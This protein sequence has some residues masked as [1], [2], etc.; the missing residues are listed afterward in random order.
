MKNTMK[1]L[2]FI[3]L[4]AVMGFTFAACGDN[5][6][7]GGG[8]GGGG[9]FTL[10]DIPAEYNG[11]DAQLSGYTVDYTISLYGAQKIQINP[12]A[13]TPCKISNGSVS[14]PMWKLSTNAEGTPTNAVRYTGNDLV[15]LSV[16]IYPEVIVGFTT[17]PVAFSNGSAT[18]SWSQGDD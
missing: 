2:G 7:D 13:L 8:G 15:V 10:T 18:R 3:A 11:K 1:F 16:S 12:P 9:T 14:L 5:D 6:D 17:T 4:V